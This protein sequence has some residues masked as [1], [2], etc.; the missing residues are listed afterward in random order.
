MLQAAVS[1]ALIAVMLAPSFAVLVAPQPAQAT[2]PVFKPI[3]FIDADCFTKTILDV[4]TYAAASAALQAFTRQIN[5]WITNL[6]GKAVGFIQNFEW[7]FRKMLNKRAQDFFAKIPG[8]RTCAPSFSIPF[9]QITI[10]RQYNYTM[11]GPQLACRLIGDIEG[12]FRGATL[13]GRDTMIRVS[14]D[15]SVDPYL[16][17]ET[18]AL[19]KIEAEQATKNALQRQM[20]ATTPFKGVFETVKRCERIQLEDADDATDFEEYCFDE[21]AVTKHGQLIE[22]TLEKSF[23]V[24]FDQLRDTHYWGQ[25]LANILGSIVFSLVSSSIDSFFF[26][27]NQEMFQDDS[28]TSGG[29]I[30]PPS[31]SPTLTANGVTG[32]VSV[33]SG[34]SVTIAWD[35]TN[36]GAAQCSIPEL[37]ATTV[38][39]SVTFTAT[40]P[41]TYTITCSTASGT[42]T[43]SVI[44][45]VIA[46][47]NL[48]ARVAGSAGAFS[49]GPLGVVT[50]TY[51]TLKWTSTNAT[52][53]SIT[54][55]SI[56]IATSGETTV[57]PLT[58]NTT[59]ALSCAGTGGGNYDTLTINIVPTLDLKINGS[60][61][62][63]TINCGGS[64][65]ASWTS[66]NADYCSVGGTV[67]A[68]SGSTSV[69]PLYS[70]Q[71][72]GLVCSGPG[73][74]ASESIRVNVTSCFTGDGI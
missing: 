46:G 71:D 70:T 30:P 7:E 35:A 60:D 74:S 64:V 10:Q 63:Q 48:T 41:K 43:K 26:E 12:Y 66:Q 25:L 42:V 58:A 31:P 2:V 18:A 11:L 15:L 50:G 59:Y 19:A 6:S 53:C 8:L 17:Y 33:S 29:Y 73:G 16:L 4:I 28:V 61:T 44:V 13:G 22:S 55:L 45:N 68:S 49:E 34:T 20:S 62:E 57:G 23:G 67:G 51:V 1:I 72:V 9:L 40:E 52:N 32:S 38:T 24:F 21:I 65:L 47:A 27:L 39:G 3:C 69:G 37:N 36:V 14:L 54:P 5:Q 56:T